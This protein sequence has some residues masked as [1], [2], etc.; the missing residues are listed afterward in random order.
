MGHYMNVYNLYRGKTIRAKKTDCWNGG[1]NMKNLV[2][3][4]ILRN[5]PIKLT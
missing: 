3:R 1:L 4:V 2:Y 5:D